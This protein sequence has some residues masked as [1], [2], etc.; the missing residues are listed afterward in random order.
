MYW[1]E[2]ERKKYPFLY[3]CDPEK[4]KE[5]SK[6]ICFISGDSCKLTHLKEYSTD[7]AIGRTLDYLRE[8]S[9]IEMERQWEDEKKE[10]AARAK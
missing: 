5:C 7:D 10:I 6:E 4:N 9:R 1:T 3:E 8:E 2:E